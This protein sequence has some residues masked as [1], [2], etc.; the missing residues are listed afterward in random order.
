[1]D[2]IKDACRVC[3]VAVTVF[4]N[5]DCIIVQAHG[6]AWRQKCHCPNTEACSQLSVPV[7]EQAIA[8]ATRESAPLRPVAIPRVARSPRPPAPARGDHAK[9]SPTSRPA[10]EQWMSAL[11]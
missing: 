10:S 11:T 1:M 5:G 6:R 8:A 3:G 2:I 7:I 4:V 9:R